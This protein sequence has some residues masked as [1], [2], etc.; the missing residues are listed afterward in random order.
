MLYTDGL[1][2]G[3]TTDDTAYALALVTGL[4]LNGASSAAS[5]IDAAAVASQTVPNRDDVAI[6]VA[7]S[8]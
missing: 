7:R 1:S 5:T 6:L 2:A 8:E 3:Q 4:S